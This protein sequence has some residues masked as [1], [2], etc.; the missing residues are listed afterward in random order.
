MF[1]P[2]TCMCDVGVSRYRKLA[3]RPVSRCISAVSAESSSFGNKAPSQSGRTVKAVLRRGP[4]L[5]LVLAVLV[6]VVV[7]APAHSGALPVAD[8]TGT[9]RNPVF[10]LDFPDPFVFDDKGT[11]TAYATNANGPN[12]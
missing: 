3:S 1:R 7:G 2:A 10:G 12:I 8:T 11:F 4:A 9:Y 5:V 6:A